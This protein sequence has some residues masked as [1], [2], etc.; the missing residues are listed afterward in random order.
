M[1]V[2]DLGCGGGRTTV[3]LFKMDYKVV[4]INISKNLIKQLNKKF[5]MIDVHVGDAANL[6]FFKNRSFDIVL[7][8]NNG[9]DCLYPKE[10]RIEALKEIYRVLKPRVFHF[11]ILYILITN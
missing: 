9:L 7:F 6:K 1:K 4:G 2:L 3:P 11:F 5:P 8:S 10:K